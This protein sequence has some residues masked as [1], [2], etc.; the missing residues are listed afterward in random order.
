[1]QGNFQVPVFVGDSMHGATGS[2]TRVCLMEA[3]L[4]AP[5]YL[6]RIVCITV[7]TRWYNKQMFL[8]RLYARNNV[9]ISARI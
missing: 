1:M 9:Q 4:F 2:A 5:K 8:L 6:V 7:R 3:P